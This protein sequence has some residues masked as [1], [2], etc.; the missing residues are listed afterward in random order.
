MRKRNIVVPN[1][2]FVQSIDGYESYPV[3]CFLSAIEGQIDKYR[4][5][6]I[7]A[8]G[9]A[10]KLDIADKILNPVLGNINPA[11]VDSFDH[12]DY[13]AMRTFKISQLQTVFSLDRDSKDSQRIIDCVVSY[14]QF[15][16]L[17]S[18]IDEI[19]R[20]H[21]RPYDEGDFKTAILIYRAD[22]FDI[23]G[24]IY[25]EIENPWDGFKYKKIIADIAWPEWVHIMYSD[26]TLFAKAEGC[27]SYISLAE[28]AKMHNVDASTVRKKIQAG[29]LRA[30]KPGHD[31]LIKRDEPWVDLRYKK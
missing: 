2:Q 30:E 7:E 20:E 27:N 11:F 18:A 25:F 8:L 19:M 6:A 4:A 23:D 22:S 24:E 14:S 9:S 17:K 26:V 12:W 15:K 1:K 13:D 29:N 3:Q 31:W 16:F 28:Y 5:C 21:V 10:E